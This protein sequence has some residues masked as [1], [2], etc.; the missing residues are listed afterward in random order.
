MAMARNFGPDQCSR[1]P[2]GLHRLSTWV[3]LPG[4]RGRND[5][6]DDGTSHDWSNSMVDDVQP[7]ISAWHRHAI[8]CRSEVGNFAWRSVCRSVWHRLDHAL[9][10]GLRL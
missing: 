6:L 4:L 9:P 10:V 1:F 7:G 5:R 8:G 3:A 2:T